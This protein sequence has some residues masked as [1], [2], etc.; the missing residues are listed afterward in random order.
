MGDNYWQYISEFYLSNSNMI[1]VTNKK[2]RK[3]AC[4]FIGRALQ[5]YLNK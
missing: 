1:E 4:K 2:Y 3:G 5:Y